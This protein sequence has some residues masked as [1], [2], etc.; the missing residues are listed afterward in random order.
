MVFDGVMEV[1]SAHNNVDGSNATIVE[2]PLSFLFYT[3]SDGIII[4]D[5][6]RSLNLAHK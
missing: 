6:N 3:Y 1:I 5:T 2:M 4:N